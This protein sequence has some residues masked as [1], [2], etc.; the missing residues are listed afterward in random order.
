MASFLVRRQTLRR[1]LLFQQ[2]SIC[3]SQLQASTNTAGNTALNSKQRLN[4]DN[5]VDWILNLESHSDHLDTN[6][7]D[8]WHMTQS[9]SQFH[10][11][12]GCKT[13]AKSQ[14]KQNN[15]PKNKIKANVLRMIVLIPHI[16]PGNSAWRKH[17]NATH[18]RVYQFTGDKTGTRQNV[19]SS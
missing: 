14:R 6:M 19:F 8:N 15:V 17:M 2:M 3:V 11:I 7:Y 4:R 1:L 16:Y 18:S 13:R 10:P 5:I 9:N 12:T